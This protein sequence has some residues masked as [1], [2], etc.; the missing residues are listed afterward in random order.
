MLA[1]SGA[2]FVAS[3]ILACQSSKTTQGV[4]SPLMVSL[5]ALKYFYAR[6]T[7]EP[8]AHH[9]WTRKACS[10]LTESQWLQDHIHTITLGK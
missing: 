8:L 6:M 2:P 1:I 5:V 10:D 9:P 7:Q 3:P 4:N